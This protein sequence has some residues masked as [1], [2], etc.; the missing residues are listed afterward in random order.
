MLVTEI[1]LASVD[2]KGLVDDRKCDGCGAVGGGKR[3]R[4]PEEKRSRGVRR[5]VWTRT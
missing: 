5:S 3:V 2:R 4:M 1:A